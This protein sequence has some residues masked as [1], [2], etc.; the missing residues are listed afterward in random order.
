MNVRKAVFPAAGLGGIS[1]WL[2]L[3]TTTL[4]LAAAALTWIVA[5]AVMWRA[6]RR[7][8]DARASR[9]AA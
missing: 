9:R 1:A 5:Y 8:D 6:R 4:G 3:G 2:F 7:A